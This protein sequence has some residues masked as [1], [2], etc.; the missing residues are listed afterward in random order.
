MIVAPNIYVV[1]KGILIGSATKLDSGSG[2]IL[3]RR[4]LNQNTTLPT[5]T[6]GVVGTPQMVF[7][8]PIMITHVNRNPGRPL[9]KSM[10]VGR[11]KNVDATNSK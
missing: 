4:N 1:R 3:A 6:I 2:G 11:Y 10:V 5:I 8:N 9:M 7:T